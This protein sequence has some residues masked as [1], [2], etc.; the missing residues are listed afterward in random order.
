V[1]WVVTSVISF[2]AAPQERCEPAI[3]D[4]S[5]TKDRG[6]PQIA[7]IQIEGIQI[8]DPQTMLDNDGGET[9]VGTVAYPVAAYL[10]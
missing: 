8:D 2:H 6:G 9:M 3:H 1:I 4:A 10:L 7:G 5:F